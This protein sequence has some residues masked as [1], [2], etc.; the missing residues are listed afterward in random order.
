[1]MGDVKRWRTLII[2]LSALVMLIGATCVWLFLMQQELDSRR[3]VINMPNMV[4]RYVKQEGR[5]PQDM[6][7]LIIA[8]QGKSSESILGPMRR[9]GAKLTVLHEDDSV[10]RIRLVLDGP[11]PVDVI[12]NIDKEELL[13]E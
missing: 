10:Y 3:F 4:R 1:M 8:I 6:E 5:Y 11:K 2:V 9:R 7:S 12:L 13:K